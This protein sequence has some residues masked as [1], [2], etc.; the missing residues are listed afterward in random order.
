M[1]LK[2]ISPLSAVLIGLL[3]FEPAS[4]EDFEWVC[5][6]GLIGQLIVEATGA[7]SCKKVPRSKMLAIERLSNDP[8]N[9][10]SEK[11]ILEW[12]GEIRA[13]DLTGMPNLQGIRLQRMG[14]KKIDSRA[15]DSTPNLKAITVIGS[16]LKDLCFLNN[17]NLGNLVWVQLNYSL[18]ENPECTLDDLSALEYL[19]LSRN[20]ISEV[21][22]DFLRGLHSLKHLTWNG[23]LSSEVVK[24]IKI[25][26]DF[27]VHNPNLES[28]EATYGYCEISAGAFRTNRRLQHVNLGSGC[29][30]DPDA[31]VGA[32]S[33][34]RLDVHSLI[35]GDSL[36]NLN[37]LTGLT[38]L[39]MS[40]YFVKSYLPDS[41]GGLNNLE[42]LALMNQSPI[43]GDRR[44]FCGLKKLKRLYLYKKEGFDFDLSCRPDLEVRYQKE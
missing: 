31:F 40:N 25:S 12:E 13:G 19:D 26:P 14:L 11:D 30:V 33:L 8:V 16:Q 42:S 23:P 28:F 35:R 36:L 24:R 43:A 3:R 4:A 29:E 41:F 21:P 10:K 2:K 15:F 27:F 1:N 17:P 18:I 37:G 9:R 6:R 5:D 38:S 39:G 22:S 34:E 7:E 44:L 20:R 32:I